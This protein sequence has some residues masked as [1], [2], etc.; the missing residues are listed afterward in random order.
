MRKKQALL[1]TIKRPLFMQMFLTKPESLK[2]S[3]LEA[4]KKW[5]I[6]W[7]QTSHFPKFDDD[8]GGSFD[9]HVVWDTPSGKANS[10]ME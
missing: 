10:T 5:K 9:K 4:C 8:Y 7:F 2:N 6:F 1:K 3:E